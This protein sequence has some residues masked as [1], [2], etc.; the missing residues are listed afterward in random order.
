MR[1]TTIGDLDHRL[2]IETESRTGDGGGG[3]DESWVA[4]GEVWGA[5]RAVG[6]DERLEADGNKGRLTQ[7][8]VIRWRADVAPPMRFRVGLRVLD[9]KAAFDPDGRRRRL[10]CLC[11]ERVP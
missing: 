9:I 6:G 10:K 3:A 2:V 5:I 7:E 4:V 1:T 11:E 8:V